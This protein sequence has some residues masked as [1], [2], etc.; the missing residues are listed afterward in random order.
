MYLARHIVRTAFSHTVEKWK[1]FVGS[2][3]SDSIRVRT[4]TQA[5]VIELS[6]HHGFMKRICISLY[7]KATAA[8]TVNECSSI[9][10]DCI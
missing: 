1:R 8:F 10:L 6:F 3:S 4:K 9:R 2:V 7:H 5:F